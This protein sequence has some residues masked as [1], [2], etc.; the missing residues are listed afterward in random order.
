[1]ESLPR[2]KWFRIEQQSLRGTPD[3]LGLIDGTF[4]AIEFKKSYEDKPTKLQAHELQKVV[5]AGGIAIVACPE[6]WDYVFGILSQIAHGEG[7]PDG[8]LIH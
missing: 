4:V 3:T 1:L 5:D 2:S 7:P 6:N 8:T